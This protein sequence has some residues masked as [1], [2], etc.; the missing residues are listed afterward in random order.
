MYRHLLSA[1][2]LSALFAAGGTAKADPAV[3]INPAGGCNMLDGNGG[4]VFTTDTKI[5]ATQS[6]N[7]NS[8]VQCKADVTPSSTGQPVRYDYASTGAQCGILNPFGA[9]VTTIWHE[10]VSASGEAM[11]ICQVHPN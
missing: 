9:Q 8:Q 10:I 3:V 7:G 6:Q 2:V 1:V 5:V 4:G 11:L